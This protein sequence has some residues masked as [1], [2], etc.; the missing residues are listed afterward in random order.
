MKKTKHQYK[1]IPV[2]AVIGWI[3]SSVSILL[4][5]ALSAL[6]I[7]KQILPQNASVEVIVGMTC[8]GIAAAIG[9]FMTGI[10]VNHGALPGSLICG[11][12][13]LLTMCI[14]NGVLGKGSFHRFV[15]TAVM[16]MGIAVISG[17]LGAR[18][19]QKYH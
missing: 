16:I 12:L 6:L 10:M 15:P 9:C 3:L 11:T 17:L 5:I 19:K 14:G 7:E 13:F 8:V 1:S 18:K 4:L 2:M